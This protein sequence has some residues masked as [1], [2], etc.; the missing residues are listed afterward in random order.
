[1]AKVQ[2][3]KVIERIEDEAYLNPSDEETPKQLASHIQPVLISNEKDIINIVKNQAISNSVSGNIYTTP[4][5]KDFYLCGAVLGVVKDGTSTSTET[6]LRVMING[7]TVRL[8]VIPT[9]TLTAERETVG[10][11]FN[12]A[13]KIDRNTT[14]TM[15]NS[16]STANISNSASIWGYEKD[17]LKK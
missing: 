16:S 10:I 13:I 14:I 6:S 17:T 3:R 15:N 2:N 1:M 11:N 8:I 12:P 5:D 9:L 4:E 7:K